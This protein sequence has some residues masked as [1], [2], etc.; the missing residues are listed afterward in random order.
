MAGAELLDS[1][2]GRRSRGWLVAP[3]LLVLVVALAV[4]AARDEGGG[5]PSPSPTTSV[6]PTAEPV[7]LT[8]ASG[9]TSALS[10][11]TWAYGVDLV[12]LWDE[13]ITVH[14]VVALDADGE[15][16]ETAV[17]LVADP[18]TPFEPEAIAGAPAASLLLPA[19]GRVE[20]RLAARPDCP[21]IA[22]P[23]ALRITYDIGQEVHE[24]VLQPGD[25]ELP[26][27]PARA[28]AG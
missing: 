11:G 7:R 15:R 14:A 2:E 5:G 19:R 24:D 25:D 8:L 26:T 27:L 18:E 10:G 21:A 13:P 4:R 17:Q 23:V 16:V 22:R 12:S 1:G 3:L 20:V 9:Y 28:C 6:S